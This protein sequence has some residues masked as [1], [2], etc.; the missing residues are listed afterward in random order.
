MVEEMFGPYRLDRLIGRGGM[1]EVYRAFDTVRSRAVAIKRLPV[2]LAADPEFQARFRKESALAAQL[3]EPHIVP[4]HNFG[5]IDGRLYIEM[6][7]VEG[8]DLATMLA[9]DGPL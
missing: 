1:G 3:N 6:R 8:R 9:E 4:I 5:E 7:L 2:P